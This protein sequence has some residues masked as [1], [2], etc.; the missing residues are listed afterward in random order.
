RGQVPTAARLTACRSTT[1]ATTTYLS[2]S[3]ASS[4]EGRR[5]CSGIPCFWPSFLRDSVAVVGNEVEERAIAFARHYLVQQGYA[6][7]DVSR[8]GGAHKGYDFL[9]RRNA[10][11]LRIEVKGCSRRWHIPD[12]Y[13][14]EFDENRRLVADFL[15]VVFFIDGEETQ[16]A[17]IPRDAI[18]P[19][20]VTP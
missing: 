1:I 18:D 4:G 10:E 15:Y 14:T 7:E 17:V 5:R 20:Y 19:A 3:A 2:S 16:L 6:V 12:A 11:E 9:V 13:A 8:K